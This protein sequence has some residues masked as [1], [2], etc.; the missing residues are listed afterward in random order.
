M[1]ACHVFECVPGWAEGNAEL[2]SDFVKFGKE[3][4]RLERFLAL[5]TLIE[6]VAPAAQLAADVVPQVN[7]AGGVHQHNVKQMALAERN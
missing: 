3:V 4:V 1:A 7:L 6:T 5:T 2:C